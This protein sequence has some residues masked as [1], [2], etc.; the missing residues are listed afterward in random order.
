[1]NDENLNKNQNQDDVN[2]VKE[3]VSIIESTDSH[4]SMTRNQHTEDLAELK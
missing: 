4:I 2:K 1:M 3:K